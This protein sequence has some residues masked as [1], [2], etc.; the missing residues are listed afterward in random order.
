METRSSSGSDSGSWKDHLLSYLY[1]TKP[2]N[3]SVKTNTSSNSSS[4]KSLSAIV[5][6][7]SNYLELTNAYTHFETLDGES[8]GTTVR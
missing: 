2:T 5:I 1:V 3:L 4:S 6:E 7:N 8:I